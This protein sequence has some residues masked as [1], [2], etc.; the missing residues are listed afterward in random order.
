MKRM[1]VRFVTSWCVLTW[2]AAAALVVCTGARLGA[3]DSRS[4]GDRYVEGTVLDAQG[5]PV[6]G[7]RITLLQQGAVRKSTLSTVEKFRID[8]LPPA[9]Y[10]IRVEAGGFET[11]S[12]TVDLQ[13]QPSASLEVRLE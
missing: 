8:Q 6:S 4:G 9:V 10:E 12:T 7:A 1:S 11:K 5:L 13:N 2:V 3:Q